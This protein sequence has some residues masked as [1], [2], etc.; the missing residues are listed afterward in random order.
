MK[1]LIQTWF[2]FED[3]T[4]WGEMFRVAVLSIVGLLALWGLIAGSIILWG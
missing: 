2:L 1:K 4:T 3:D